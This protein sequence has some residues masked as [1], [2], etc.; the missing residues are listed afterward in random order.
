MVGQASSLFVGAHGLG[1]LKILHER[2]IVPRCQC[3]DGTN[4]IAHVLKLAVGSKQPL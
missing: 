4:L 3:R 1:C 2:E